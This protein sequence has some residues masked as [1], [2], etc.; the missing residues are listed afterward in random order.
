MYGKTN[1]SNS[2]HAGT[3]LIQL[4]ILLPKTN[5]QEVIRDK[6]NAVQNW[7][8]FTE[9]DTWK[10]SS[11]TNLIQFK[12]I[13]ITERNTW[14]NKKDNIWGEVKR[15]YFMRSICLSDSDW[16]KSSLSWGAYWLDLSAWWL[17]GILI[18]SRRIALA[19]VVPK[20]FRSCPARTVFFTL[21]T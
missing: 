18:S 19:L 6:P 20:L 8:T 1:A 7:S 3:K 10:R 13:T 2:L 17:L 15:L 4:L 16:I 11:E 12:L 21:P 9:S 14:K 5:N